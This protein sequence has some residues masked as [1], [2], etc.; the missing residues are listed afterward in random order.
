MFSSYV[1][2]IRIPSEFVQLIKLVLIATRNT[3]RLLATVVL[4]GCSSNFQNVYEFLEIF[5]YMPL[6]L[7]RKEQFK[8][9]AAKKFSSL[10]SLQVAVGTA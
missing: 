5:S 8:F 6:R 4:F 9:T 3:L 10:V 1:L 7:S 2:L